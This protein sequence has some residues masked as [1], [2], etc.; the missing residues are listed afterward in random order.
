MD[1][2]SWGA[3]NWGEFI[4]PGVGKGI[5]GYPGQGNPTDILILRVLRPFRPIMKKF[6]PR[7][8]SDGMDIYIYDK[9][10]KEELF[11]IRI[12]CTKAEFNTLQSW[13]DEKANGAINR[14][15]WIDPYSNE[16]LVRIM[17]EALDDWQEEAYD[18]YTGS[19]ILRK[20]G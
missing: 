11:E 20:E 6:Q 19:L 8:Y 7:D 15:Y 3:A 9:A 14:L 5:F 1:N 13:F 18:Q 12:K 4:W 17:N 16:H 10:G 2:L